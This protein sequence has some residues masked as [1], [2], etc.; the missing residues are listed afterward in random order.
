MLS[1]D[2]ALTVTIAF[3]GLAIM[4]VVDALVIRYL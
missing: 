4:A 3:G 2:R 1:R